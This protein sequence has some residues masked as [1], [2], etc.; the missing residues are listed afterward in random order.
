MTGGDTLQ[1][2]LR[3]DDSLAWSALA[4]MR[5]G[6]DAKLAELAGRILDRRL[7]K[8][9]DMNAAYEDPEPR[10]RATVRIRKRSAQ[11]DPL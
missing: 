4:M 3:L 9:L 1:N 10:R 11:F 6:S 8:V 2:Y 7:Y 5:S